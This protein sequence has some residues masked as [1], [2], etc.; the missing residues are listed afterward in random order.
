MDHG[1]VGGGER[2]RQ[3]REGDAGR[4]QIAHRLHSQLAWHEI[5]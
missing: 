5:G 3:E 2:I 4:P 1:L